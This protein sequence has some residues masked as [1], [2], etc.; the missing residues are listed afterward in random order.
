M[1]SLRSLEAY[2]CERN[3]AHRWWPM[4]GTAQEEVNWIDPLFWLLAKI[5]NLEEVSGYPDSYDIVSFS[6]TSFLM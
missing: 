4:R 5:G 6:S 2:E 3:Y 1:S